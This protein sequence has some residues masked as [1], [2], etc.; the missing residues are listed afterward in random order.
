VVGRKALADSRREV[1]QLAA[2]SSDAPQ[3]AKPLRQFLQTIDD[4]KR[5]VENDPRAAAT[6]PPAPDKTHIS[7]NGGFTGMEAI[8]NYFYWQAL[9]T[10]GLDNIG[11]ILRLNITLGCG[12]VN[13]VNN[14]NSGQIKCGNQFLGPTQPGVTTPDPTAGAKASSTANSAPVAQAVAAATG[15]SDGADATRLLDYL[16]AP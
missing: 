5:A 4:R 10:N 11:H 7:G 9:S 12:T 6:G 1:D 14:P 3:L 13:Y 15:S 16:L 8:W 2:L